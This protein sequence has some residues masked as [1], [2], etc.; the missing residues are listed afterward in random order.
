M[1]ERCREEVM[2]FQGADSPPRNSPRDEL[3]RILR[4]ISSFVTLPPGVLCV[5]EF[6]ESTS[7][8]S[9]FD[10]LDKKG[11]GC[12]FWRRDNVS[13]TLLASNRVDSDVFSGF[14][15]LFCCCGVLLCWVEGTGCLAAN[16]CSLL[17]SDVCLLSSL[18]SSSSKCLRFKFICGCG[19]NS[20]KSSFSSFCC[21]AIGAIAV[22]PTDSAVWGTISLEFLPESV[23]I[24]LS[25]A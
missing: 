3:S 6:G 22:P 5:D 8:S 23:S 18:D 4:M 12:T 1:S 15:C 16:L 11:L 13:D 19:E 2:V 25:N 21:N 9:N 10:V 20:E 24:S 17:T 14:C 7:I